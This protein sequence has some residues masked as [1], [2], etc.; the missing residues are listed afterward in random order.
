M[1]NILIILLLILTA[2]SYKEV[3]NMDISKIKIEINSNNEVLINGELV[4]IND[5]GQKLIDLK[6]KDSIKVE[7][8]MINLDIDEKSDNEIVSTIKL[9]LRKA[10]LLQ[11]EYNKN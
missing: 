10:D 4:D 8:Y 3:K 5:I 1:K 11:I 7:N 2:C 9:E 6:S